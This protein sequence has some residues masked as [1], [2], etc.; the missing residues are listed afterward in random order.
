MNSYK[1]HENKTIWLSGTG[2]SKYNLTYA[3]FQIWTC[4]LAVPGGFTTAPFGE[5]INDT[6]KQKLTQIVNNSILYQ[7]DDM[8]AAAQ[9][10]QS[11]INLIIGCRWNV[12][13]SNS[14][15]ALGTNSFA[16]Y[17]CDCYNKWAHFKAFGEL[18]WN[19]FIWAD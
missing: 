15:V 16:Y 12:I 13:I 10:I 14:S 11:K 3:M 4:A 6:V 18:K 9:Y 19:Y 1:V 2:V 17:R 5:N 8:Y 7:G